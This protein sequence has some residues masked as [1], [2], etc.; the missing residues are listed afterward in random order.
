MNQLYVFTFFSNSAKSA[1]LQFGSIY[2]DCLCVTAQNASSLPLKHV[3]SG[4]GADGLNK[5]QIYL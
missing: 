4:N 5:T 1:I 2:V 3:C